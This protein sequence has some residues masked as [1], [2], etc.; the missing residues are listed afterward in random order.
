MSDM[1]RMRACN[2]LAGDEVSASLNAPYQR[3]V[4]VERVKADCALRLAFADGSSRVFEPSRA[5]FVRPGERASAA[6]RQLDIDGQE[7][8]V[9]PQREPTQPFKLA[10]LFEHEPHLAGQTWLALAE[11]GE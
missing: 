4:R 10:P 9:E 5:L 3:V 2:V 6:A 1:R 11:L 7:H 8:D